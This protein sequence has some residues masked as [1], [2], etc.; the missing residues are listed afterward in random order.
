[1]HKTK[2]ISR[3]L[4]T[5]C[6]LTLIS[7]CERAVNLNLKNEASHVV[8]EAELHPAAGGNYVL[9][10]RT[11]KVQEDAQPEAIMGAKVIITDQNENA[12]ELT[13]IEAGKYQ[14]INITPLSGEKYKLQI[15]IN[16][17]SEITGETQL[18][19]DYV[20]I[21]SLSY[22]SSYGILLNPAIIC[23]LIDPPGTTNYYRIRY[24]VNGN[25]MVPT[26]AYDII[27]S[28]DETWE[29][30]N[31]IAIEYLENLSSG[32][33]VTIYL[34]NVDSSYFNYY[35]TLTSTDRNV[36]GILGTNPENPTGNLGEN[37]FGYFGSYSQDTMSIVIP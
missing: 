19:T 9:L 6:L 31:M 4:F 10:H 16:G 3:I 5:L 23:H 8:V 1:M 11:T 20:K 25:L 2:Y 36:G 28:S 30:E 15:Q 29:T 26:S 27:M 21:D 35:S 18:P 34:M 7:A 24:A 12:F 17:E 13:E 14:N 32:D 37:V 22:D 33:L